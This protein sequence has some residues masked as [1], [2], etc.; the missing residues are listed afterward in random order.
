MP[1]QDPNARQHRPFILDGEYPAPDVDGFSDAFQEEQDK[2][3]YA[4]KHESGPLY[5]DYR[6]HPD[7]AMPRTPE[8]YAQELEQ[9]E[10]LRA[11]HGGLPDAPETIRPGNPTPWKGMKG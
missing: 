3:E 5:G 6:H 10:Y 2:R 9:Q 7:R 1:D 8:M 4:A 11:C